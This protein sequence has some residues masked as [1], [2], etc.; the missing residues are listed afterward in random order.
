MAATTCYAEDFESACIS[1]SFI[2]FLSG[3]F[4][5]QTAV[6]AELEAI[7]NVIV[8]RPCHLSPARCA[9]MPA[10]GDD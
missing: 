7:V 5:R 1:W 3:F 4:K 9:Q 6:I 8:S 10:K 2:A